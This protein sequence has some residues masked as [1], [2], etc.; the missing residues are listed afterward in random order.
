MFAL[1]IH[2]VVSRWVCVC[3]V[4]AESVFAFASLFQTMSFT[5]NNI[6]ISSAK[7]DHDL[8]VQCSRGFSCTEVSVTYSPINRCFSF[9]LILFVFRRRLFF[10]FASN[11]NRNQVLFH[12]LFLWQFKTTLYNHTPQRPSKLLNYK[13]RPQDVALSWG[14]ECS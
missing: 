14:F 8:N 10:S 2:T 7:H 4:R 9:P 6:N 13:P 11:R 3:L 12:V 1:G 5:E